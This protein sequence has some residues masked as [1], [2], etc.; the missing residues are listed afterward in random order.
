MISPVT[1]G[2]GDCAVERAVSATTMRAVAAA[3]AL[4]SRRRSSGGRRNCV[5]ET[6]EERAEV[7]SEGHEE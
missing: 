1:K 2:P 6:L 4:V 3:R 7:Q 5:L